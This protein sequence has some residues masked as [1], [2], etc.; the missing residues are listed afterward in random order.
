[1]TN[2]GKRNAMAVVAWLAVAL[3]EGCAFVGYLP[4]QQTI[5]RLRVLGP[6]VFLN[7]KPARDGQLITSGDR[8]RTG[9][10]S[11]VYLYF[12]SGGFL[13]FDENTDPVIEIV[14]RGTSC[15]VQ[16]QGMRQGQAYEETNPQC[17]TAVNTPH[18]EATHDGSIFNIKVD[19]QQTVLTALDGKL[20]LLSPKS[21]ELQKGQQLSE[22]PVGIGAIRVL[23]EQELREVVRWR[24]RF[25]APCAS[26][27][28][29]CSAPGGSPP[30]GQCCD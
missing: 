22:S 25:P 6:N 18:G 24:N 11:S 12:L 16:V 9:T 29:S 14:W 13:Q 30:A 3:L 17:R 10:D 5:G 21:V 4:G 20:I 2:A 23:S 28:T 15:E 8:L 26:D 1:M 7:D 19:P 27:G